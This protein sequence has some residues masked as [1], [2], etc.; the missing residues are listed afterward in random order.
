[1]SKVRIDAATAA[2]ARGLLAPVAGQVAAMPSPTA[3]GCGSA[4]VERA[5]AVFAGWLD[6][7]ATLATMRV[8]ALQQSLGQMEERWQRADDSLGTG[9]R[10]IPR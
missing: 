10:Q 4:D 7:E 3:S 1:M 6:A 5:L 9:A 2:S 8:Q